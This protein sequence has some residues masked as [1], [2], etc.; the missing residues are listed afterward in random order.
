MVQE[1]SSAFIVLQLFKTECQVPA[2]TGK[3]RV[4]SYFDFIKDFKIL[5]K[6]TVSLNIK[7]D[8]FMI[9]M[10]NQAFDFKRFFPV[11]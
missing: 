5:C 7:I 3:K 1:A 9:L 10:F 8:L 2:L 6:I 4:E 11:R